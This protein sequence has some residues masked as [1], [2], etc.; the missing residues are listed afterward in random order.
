M[1]HPFLVY[2]TVFL[3]VL[4]L[5]PVDSTVS[6]PDLYLVRVISTFWLCTFPTP[7]LWLSSTLSGVS[8][9]VKIGP[10]RHKGRRL[11]SLTRVTN[12]T[13]TLVGVWLK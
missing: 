13:F 1:T 2:P 6:T 4:T 10:Q 8:V 12:F 5:G 3:T 9:R 7:N 11:Y